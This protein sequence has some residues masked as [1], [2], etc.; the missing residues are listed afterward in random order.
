MREGYLLQR[1]K[2]VRADSAIRLDGWERRWGILA[3][4][5]DSCERRRYVKLMPLNGG[6]RDGF[7]VG[8][9]GDGWIMYDGYGAENPPSA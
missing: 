6:S 1:W 3:F 7:F 4:G 2:E 9:Q 8:L 5:R